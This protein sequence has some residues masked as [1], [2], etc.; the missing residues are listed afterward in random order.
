MKGLHFNAMRFIAIDGHNMVLD[1]ATMMNFAEADL[2]LEIKVPGYDH[3]LG[4]M[5]METTIRGSI[6]ETN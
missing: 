6:M 4:S 1:E 5:V 3:L 2:Q